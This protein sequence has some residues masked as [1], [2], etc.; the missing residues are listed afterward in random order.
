V[1]ERP[2][3][4]CLCGSA[5]F[6]GKFNKCYL[7]ETLAGRV[8]LSIATVPG[9]DEALFAGFSESEKNRVV[10]MLDELHRHKIDLADEVLIINVGGYM[11]SSTKRELAYAQSQGKKIRF[12]ES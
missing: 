7:E 9:G 5:R 1:T 3:I 10:T 8:V 4:V 6:G 2:V 12:L 11:G